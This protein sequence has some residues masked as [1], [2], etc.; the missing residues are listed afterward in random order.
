MLATPSICSAW[1]GRYSSCCSCCCWRRSSYVQIQVRRRLTEAEL[2]AHQLGQYRLV[3]KRRRRHGCG[4]QGAPC[5]APQRDRTQT[6]STYKADDFTI[7]CFEQEVQLTCALTHP[8]AIQAFDYGHTSDGIFHYAMEY[9]DSLSL[10]DLVTAMTRGRRVA[11]SMYYG[12]CV[13]H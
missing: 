10:A 6:A 3:E 7:S 2:K 4:L 11:S 13:T 8:N 1:C 12:R 5:P 9:L